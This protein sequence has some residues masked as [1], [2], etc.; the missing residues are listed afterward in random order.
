MAQKFLTIE[1]LVRKHFLKVNKAL[2]SRLKVAEVLGVSPRC[3]GNYRNKWLKK[4]K[5]YSS[6][7]EEFLK[8]R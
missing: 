6:K 3:V 7:N 2:K 1:E 5:E 4:R 8:E